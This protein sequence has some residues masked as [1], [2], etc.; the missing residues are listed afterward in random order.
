MTVGQACDTEHSPRSA[1]GKLAPELLHCIF[2]YLPLED[3]LSLR[4]TCVILSSAG[5][6]C[7]GTEVPLVAHHDNFQALTEIAKHTVLSNRMKSMFY[8]CDRPHAVRDRAWTN[9]WSAR[10]DI[11][12]VSASHDAY[13]AFARSFLELCEYYASVK[14][15]E[16]ERDCLRELFQ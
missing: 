3:V 5:L 9:S 10:Q 2:E 13:N 8:M 6:N 4:R 12:G 16:Y 11:C 14:H 15:Q 1:L 7:F